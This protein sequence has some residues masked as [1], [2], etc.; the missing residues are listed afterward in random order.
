MSTRSRQSIGYSTLV[1]LFLVFG[2]AV[3]ASNVL[4]RGVRLDLTENQLYTLS[5]G[6]VKMLRGIDEPIHLYLF[7]SNEP[8]KDLPALRA[9]KQRVQEMLQE[10][11]AHAPQGKL[12]L[13]D[14]DPV[15][16]S[17]DEDRAS[18]YGLQAANIGPGGE[19]VYFGLA[20]TNSVGTTDHIPFFDPDPSKESFL[21]YQLARLVYNLAHPKKAVVGLLSSVPMTGGFDPQTQQPSQPWA[22][23]DQIKQLFD[24]RMVP[25]KTLH[26]DDDINV[27]WVVHPVNLDDDTKYAIDQFVMRGGRALIFVD[28]VAEVAS[29]G[30]PQLGGG[31]SSTLEPL[32]TA[33]G[34]KFS[35]DQVVAD[36]RYAL[37]VPG[38]FRPVRHLGLL[39]LDMAAMDQK[40]VI[41]AGLDTINLGLAGHFTLADGA[42]VKFTP[43]LRSSPQSELI[44]AERFQFLSDPGELLNG[45]VPSGKQYVLA[46]RLEGPLKSAYPNGPP[47]VPDRQQPVDEALKSKHLASTDDANI[48]LVGD[49]D[50]LSDRLWVQA[51]NFLGQRLMNAFANNGDFVV[52]AL[53]NLSGSADLIGLRSR[54]TYSRPFTRVEALRRQ[55][56]AKFRQTEQQLQAQLSETERKLGQL[57]S[58][59]SD[60]GSVLMTPEQQQEIQQFLDQQVKI[61]S[62]L[63]AVRRNLDADI[64][65][66]G[67]ILEVVNIAVVPALLTIIALLVVFVKRSRKVV[68]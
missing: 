62:E 63:R 22:I 65:R 48:V 42:K 11:V 6:T 12:I 40:D 57:Q 54:A 68:Q 56:D 9:Y 10:F 19:P 36:N 44:P 55:A 29:A 5:P 66:L 30:G 24:V 18:Q 49:V 33:W 25:A 13:E 64:D 21:E 15:R 2:A 53:D 43:L 41:T 60:K 28:P 34:V 61:R 45:F 37:S 32:F 52:N 27:L 20:G 14:V 16:Y 59:R 3:M 58:S 50:V 1:V 39:G 8:T 67:T 26:I 35:T 51:Q 38:N 23:D 31:R 7:F 4:L 46:A 47:T 17:E